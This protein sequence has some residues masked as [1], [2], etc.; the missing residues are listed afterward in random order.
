M[1]ARKQRKSMSFSTAVFVRLWSVTFRNRFHGRMMIERP[2]TVTMRKGLGVVCQKDVMVALSVWKAKHHT[3]VSP[4]AGAAAFQ[5]R[6][7]QPNT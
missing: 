7:R 3:R 4:W 1:R 5:T 6:N 2:R